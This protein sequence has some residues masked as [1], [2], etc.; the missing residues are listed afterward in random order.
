MERFRPWRF[1]TRTARGRARNG[2]LYLLIVLTVI[3][4]GNYGCN[5]TDQAPGKYPIAYLT[6]T[7]PNLTLTDQY[8]HPLALA[9]LKGK[10]VLFDFI[11]TSC[12]GPCQMLTQHMKLIADKVGPALGQKLLFVSVTIDPEHD[13]PKRLF[14][15]AKTFDANMNGWYFVTG[16]SA[17]INQL[18]KGFRLTAEREADG[19][20]DHILGFFLIGSDGRPVVEYSQRVEPSLAARDVEQYAAGATLISR[21]TFDLKDWI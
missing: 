1:P 14:D 5:R 20:I 19:E 3:L 13:Q 9:S 17:Q 15:Y 7:L 4:F 18:L 2:A 16:S 6:D 21:L 10:P 12:P 11:Y 8:D